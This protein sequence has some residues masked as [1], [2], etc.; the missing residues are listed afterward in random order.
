VRFFLPFLHLIFVGFVSLFPPVNPP[1]SALLINP[2]L[3][4]LNV[5]KRRKASLKIASYAFLICTTTIF[6][7]SWIFKLFGISLPVVQLAGGILI[8]KMGWSLLSYEDSGKGSQETSDPGD[9]NRKIEDILFYPLAFPMTTGAA[10]IAVLL[11]LSAHGHNDDFSVYLTHLLALVVSVMLMCLLVFFCYTYTPALVR[12][13]G[14]RGSQ[15]LNRL[16]A[17]LVF[18]VGIQIASEGLANLMKI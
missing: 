17:F 2:L 8:C 15:V 5:P 12:N 4:W 10:T 6:I 14:P 13:L 3:K 11:T 16:S 7:G 9:I 1:G 18:C